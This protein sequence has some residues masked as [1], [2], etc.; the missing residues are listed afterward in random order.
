MVII[1]RKKVNNGNKIIFEDIKNMVNY[2]WQIVFCFY[3]CRKV[4]VLVWGVEY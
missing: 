2:K 3:F 4:V 1:G